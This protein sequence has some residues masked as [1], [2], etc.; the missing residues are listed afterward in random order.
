MRGDLVD[1][2]PFG[3]ESVALLPLEIRAAPIVFDTEAQFRGATRA[4]LHIIEQLPLLSIDVRAV[5]LDDIAIVTQVETLFGMLDDQ[6]TRLVQLEELVAFRPGR[7]SLATMDNRIRVI[8][9]RFVANV[10]TPPR[11][12][13]ALDLERGCPW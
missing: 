12:L 4:D 11:I 7:H 6:T 3:A 10:S 9:S 8:E 1:N 5:L 2:G 13:D